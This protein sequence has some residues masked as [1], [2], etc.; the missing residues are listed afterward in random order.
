MHTQD[1]DAIY[2]TSIAHATVLWLDYIATLGE[3]IAMLGVCI[4]TLGFQL[5][6]CSTII[7]LHAQPWS[8]NALT[9]RARTSATSPTPSTRT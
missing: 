4:A 6:A 3:Y 5:S 2:I 8:A 1:V 7:G 9:M